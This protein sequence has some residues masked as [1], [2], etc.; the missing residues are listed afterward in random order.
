MATLP[1]GTT[2]T[3]QFS[4]GW[5][6]AGPPNL[7]S[8]F[9]GSFDDSGIS[10]I[11]QQ[12]AEAW[13]EILRVVSDF[14]TETSK[15]AVTEGNTFTLSGVCKDTQDNPVDCTLYE[16]DGSGPSPIQDILPD[17]AGDWSYERTAPGSGEYDYFIRVDVAGRR[18]TEAWNDA[19]PPPLASQF[20]AG[21]DDGGLSGVSK[22]FSEG[23]DG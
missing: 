2:V 21:W 10:A 6:D 14:T 17:G 13:D 5:D 19:G 4:A 7:T 8:Q 11:S 16:D 1:D 23:W 12:Y 18:M 20:S 9:S 15:S 3:E 22:Q